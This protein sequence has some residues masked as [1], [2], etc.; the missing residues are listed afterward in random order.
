MIEQINS[1]SGYTSEGVARRRSE[2]RKSFTVYFEEDAL[3]DTKID[4]IIRSPGAPDVPPVGT[5]VTERGDG[6]YR[7]MTTALW[8]GLLGRWSVVA[9][10]RSGG[11]VVLSAKEMEPY[12]PPEK[13]YVVELVGE[14]AKNRVEALLSAHGLAGE[15]REVEP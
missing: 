9:K 4:V 7:V 13:K 12:I 2:E 1:F 15:V 10:D 3:N 14:Q 5:M 6:P 11:L 8:D